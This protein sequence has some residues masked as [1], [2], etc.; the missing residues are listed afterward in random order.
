MLG[1]IGFITI[2]G[3]V[4]GTLGYILGKLKNK[5]QGSKSSE[6]KRTNDFK[7]VQL[8]ENDFIVRIINDESEKVN[9][10]FG[11]SDERNSVLGAH[12]QSCWD[13][14]SKRNNGLLNV[15][16]VLAESTTVCKHQ[17]EVCYVGFMIGNRFGRPN[18]PS[19]AL[20]QI[21]RNLGKQGKSED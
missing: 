1:I 18:I 20:E 10:V 17:N 15:S 14:N 21:L 19:D 8:T 4:T 12:V 13:N 16:E 11:I 5:N 3:L 6:S 7:S 9:E 2:I